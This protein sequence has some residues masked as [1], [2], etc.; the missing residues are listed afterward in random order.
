[1]RCLVEIEYSKNTGYLVELVF[2][3]TE[4]LFQ[5]DTIEN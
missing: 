1:V 4:A 3:L 2:R 5:S